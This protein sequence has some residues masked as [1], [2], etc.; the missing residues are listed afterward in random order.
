[1]RQ[2]ENYTGFVVSALILTLGIFGTFQFY[3]TREPERI[4]TD[5]K[6]DQ[7]I[8]TTAGR[9]LYSENCMMCHGEQGEGVDGPPLNDKMFLNNTTD[10]R[11]FSLISSGVPSSEMPAWGQPFGGPL[12]D[13][14]MNQLVVYIR[15]WQENAPDRQAE[16]LQGDA[17]Q[18]LL[19]F[20]NT[21][22][23]CHG[24]TG[25]G[26]EIAPALNDPE[27]LGQLDDEWYIDTIS[28]GRPAQG[29]P[30]W[31]TVLSPVEIR[32]LVALLRAWESGETVEPPGPEEELAEA[33][34]LLDHGD[35][36][37]AEHSLQTAAEG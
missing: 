4:T 28:Q 1:M 5:E 25:V 31:G 12:T 33:L 36:H 8:A 34:H 10:E 7:L 13:Q 26:T 14:Q 21:C 16:A 22:V 11:I 35:L 20:N 23:V 37:A 3:I 18:G 24:E 9:T 15:E 29:M 30:T 32:D 2:N 17:V 27:K 19:I 6:R